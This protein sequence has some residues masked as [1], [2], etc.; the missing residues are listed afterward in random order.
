MK[1]KNL[2]AIILKLDFKKAYN[3]VISAFLQDALMRKCFSSGI[4]YRAGGQ[5]AIKINGGKLALFYE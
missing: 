1:T 4:V 5:T 2:H 3:I